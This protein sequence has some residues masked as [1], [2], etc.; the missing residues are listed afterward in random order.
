[1]LAVIRATRQSKHLTVGASPR[2][3]IALSRAAQAHALLA[4]RDYTLPDDVKALAVSVLAHRVLG[5]TLEGEGPA[6]EREKV[7]ADLL[8]S[9]EVPL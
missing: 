3:S 7:I 6:D 9:V 1:M 2:G 5:A 4:G 8:E